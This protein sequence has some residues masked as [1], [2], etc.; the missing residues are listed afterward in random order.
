MDLDAN[1]PNPDSTGSEFLKKKVAIVNQ[2]GK[3]LPVFY[4]QE[5]GIKPP[6]EFRV[7]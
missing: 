3:I 7:S 4:I 6:A 1:M 5:K 2:K